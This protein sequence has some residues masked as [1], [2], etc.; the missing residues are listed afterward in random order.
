MSISPTLV[1][2]AVE[3][4][5]PAIERRQHSLTVVMPANPVYVD[6]DAARFTQV[7]W[8]LLNNAAKFMSEGG[9]IE[10]SLEEAAGKAI[11]RVRDHGI[12]IAHEMLERVF[13]RF[14]QASP[15]D[16]PSDG[17]GIGLAVAR[18]IVELHGGTIVARSDGPGMGSDFTVIVPIAQAARSAAEPKTS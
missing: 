1:E 8:N 7:L 18:T 11:V 6:V 15:D 16:M 10:L 2:Q 17:L 9:G 3:A 4:A 12:G 5:S 13:D 14:V